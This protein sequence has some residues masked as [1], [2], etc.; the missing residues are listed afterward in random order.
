MPDKIVP[1]SPTV[2]AIFAEFTAK[3]EAEKILDASAV[4]S[5]ADAL[6]EQKLDPASLRTAIFSPIKGAQ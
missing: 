3:I 5:L 6:K 1:L 2:G 4:A